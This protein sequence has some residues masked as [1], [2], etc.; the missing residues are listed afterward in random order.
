MRCAIGCIAVLAAIGCNAP[1]P[2]SS[3]S[4][5]DL[6]IAASMSATIDGKSWSATF[7]QVSTPADASFIFVSGSS[8]SVPTGTSILLVFPRGLGQHLF[9]PPI[10]GGHV[11][12]G[13]LMIGYDPW[14]TLNGGNGSVTVDTLAEHRIVGTF[15]FTGGTTRDMTP[16]TRHITAGRFAISY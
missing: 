9:V 6:Q 1:D 12:G 11:E 4:V 7:T 2:I 16:K 3:P 5:V 14:S 8:G 15:E 10:Q 13:Q